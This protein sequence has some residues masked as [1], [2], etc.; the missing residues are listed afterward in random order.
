MAK[1]KYIA[2][3][4]SSYSSGTGNCVEVGGAGGL[5]AI[6]DTKQSSGSVLE[7][8]AAAWRDFLIAIKDGKTNL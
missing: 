1:S 2:W 6:R 8:G 7:F 5:V 3:R 4:K